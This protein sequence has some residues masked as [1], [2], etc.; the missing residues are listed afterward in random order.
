M[1]KNIVIVTAPN[2]W[3][4]QQ[5]AGHPAQVLDLIG[6]AETIDGLCSLLKARLTPEEASPATQA[7]NLTPQ[8][9]RRSR[10]SPAQG[11]RAG[12]ES[13]RAW[14][15]EENELL[16]NGHGTRTSIETIAG[17]LRR[18]CGSVYAQMLKLDLKPRTGDHEA[19]QKERASLPTLDLSHAA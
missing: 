15:E 8:P 4:V 13:R 19:V 17:A 3:I 7:T 6:V 12:P 5:D 2:G 16:R 9:S 18:N 1:S 14:T 10:T 11:G